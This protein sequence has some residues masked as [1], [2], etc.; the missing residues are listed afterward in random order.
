MIVIL[1]T[2]PHKR[3][4]AEL[5]EESQ[6]SL[7]IIALKLCEPVNKVLKFPVFC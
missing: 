5:V 6:I 2:L 4:G 1:R 3:E 7:I